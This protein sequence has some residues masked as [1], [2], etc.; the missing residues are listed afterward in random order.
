MLFEDD[1]AGAHKS[2]EQ[3]YETNPPSG[4]EVEDFSEGHDGSCHASAGCGMCGDFPPEVDDSAGELYD[5]RGHDD[6]AYEMRC[7]EIAQHIET[8]EIAEYGDDV[9]YH[10]SFLGA[11]FGV[12]PSL[13]FMIGTYEHGREE[14]GERI[15][16]YEGE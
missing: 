15:D 13:V 6:A 4:V 1:A 10:A 14:D 12:S 3:E 16:Q 8:T 9:R 7:V 2:C 5:Q 11:F